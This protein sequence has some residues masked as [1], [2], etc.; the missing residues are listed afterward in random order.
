MPL[1]TTP[2]GNRI[3]YEESGEGT[4]FVLAH[5]FGASLEMWSWQQPYLAEGR[6]LIL[7]DALGH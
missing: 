4:P 6:R 3:R 1:I 2:Q 5:G 7:W